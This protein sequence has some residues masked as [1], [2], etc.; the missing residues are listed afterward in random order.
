VIGVIQKPKDLPE[1][2]ADERG[3]KAKAFTAKDAK[4]RKGDQGQ[5]KV[6]QEIAK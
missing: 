5:E 3:S 4:E 1:I 6:C 2:C